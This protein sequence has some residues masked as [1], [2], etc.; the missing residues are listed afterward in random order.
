MNTTYH[1]NRNIVYACTYHVVWCP[2]Y[3]RPVLT[4]DVS[5]RLRELL[6]SHATTI[7]VGVL[8]L[9]VLPDHIHLVLDVDPQ[10]GIHKAVKSLKGHTSRIL[11]EEF[12]ELTTRLPTL[13]TNSYFVATTGGVS[14]EMIKH[15]IQQQKTSQRQKERMG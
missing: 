8:E 15:Y 4:G 13:W 1:S 3:R 5:V 9:E 6:L 10:F 12:P 14:L 2:K 7:A 11:R